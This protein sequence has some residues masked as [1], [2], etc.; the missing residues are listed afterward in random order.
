VFAGIALSGSV[1]K[2]DESDDHALYGPKV[3][4]KDILIRQDVHDPTIA[5]QLDRILD[6]YSPHGGQSLSM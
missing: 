3:T 5:R 2:Q 6:K 1:I 4:P